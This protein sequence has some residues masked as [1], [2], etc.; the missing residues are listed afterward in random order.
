MFVVEGADGTLQFGIRFALY[1]C[2]F[3]VFLISLQTEQTLQNLLQP[4]AIFSP[5]QAG[6]A[7]INCDPEQPGFERRIFVERFQGAQSGEEGLLCTVI[8]F[9]RVVENGEGQPVHILL[10]CPHHFFD[11]ERIS[12]PALFEPMA[13]HDG[14]S[15]GLDA[16][17]GK[18]LHLH[19]YLG[20]TFE[21][22]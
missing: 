22:L 20:Y 18:N 3:R 2:F 9:V 7:Y 10:I 12:L 19:F 17:H 14:H 8:C 4:N 11:G 21:R 15:N 6:T 1:R 13:V 16:S 5:S